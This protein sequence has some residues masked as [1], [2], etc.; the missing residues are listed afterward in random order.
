MEKK[1][2]LDWKK[3]RKNASPV[4]EGFLLATSLLFVFAAFM[5]TLP[6]FLH[7]GNIDFVFLTFDLSIATYLLILYFFRKK[8]PLLVQI[9]SLIVI[10]LI[11]SILTF[12]RY[13]LVGSGQIS[14]AFIIITF[15]VFLSPKQSISMSILLSLIPAGFG[16]FSEYFDFYN[17][18]YDFK[19]TTTQIDWYFCSLSLIVY[20]ILTGFLIFRLR[21]KIV[22]NIAY[23][24]SSKSK[25]IDS[26]LKIEKLA[27]FNSITLLPNRYYFEEIVF[28]KFLNKQENTFILLINLKGLKVIN[29][30]HGIAFGDQIL[31]LIGKVLKNYTTDRQETIAASLGGDEFILWIE[32]STKERIEKAIQK[33]DLNN[34]EI[35]T[36]DRLGHRLLYW[37][38]GIQLNKNSESLSELIRKLSIAMNI[39]REQS[40]TQLIWYEEGMEAKIEREEKLKIS[41][42]RAVRE[43]EFQIAYQEKIDIR[44][45]E[46]VGIEA[47]ARWFSPDYGNIS[48]NEFIPIITKSEL[49][50]PFGKLIFK[51]V[52]LQIPNII[53][54]YGENIKISINISPI[55]FLYPGFHEFIL[56]CLKEYNVIAKYIMFEITEDVFVD[57][58][59]TIEK[60]VSK[61][62]DVGIS[63]SLDDFGKGYSSLH[64]MQKIQLDELKIDKSF[65]ENITESDRNFHLLK[66]ICHLA[67]SLGLK[68][69]V[70]G[71]ET[72]E[73][74]ELLGQTSCEVVQGFYFSYPQVLFK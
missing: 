32:N 69:V 35:L 57:E 30:L 38:S 22:K 13:G 21:S 9:S 20:S 41:L 60:I 44:T 52:I 51:K 27:L 7:K 4:L 49:I 14:L 8:I 70:E 71:V 55:F 48:P 42:E 26:K 6:V 15:L 74:L 31:S 72:L 58:M 25:I 29:A 61:L 17:S 3:F 68:T 47:L 73:Q 11:I 62:R 28:P 39:A 56:D 34:N 18:V 50:V 63:I 64:Y 16:I 54:K 40:S 24:N 5:N 19:K 53:V 36:P 46:V 33:F 65:V 1:E 67:N 59:E 66:S 2:N 10:G 43:D 37:V 45:K 23:L 12:V